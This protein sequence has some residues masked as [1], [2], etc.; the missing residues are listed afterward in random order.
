MPHAYTAKSYGHLQRNQLHAYYFKNVVSCTPLATVTVELRM[1]V[2]ARASTNLPN[3]P[4]E[5]TPSGHKAVTFDSNTY[6]HCNNLTKKSL[7]CGVFME[8]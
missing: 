7:Y 1:T 3:Q 4:T 6:V 5:K 8:C 2:M